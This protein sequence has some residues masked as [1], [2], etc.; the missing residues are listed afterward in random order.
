MKIVINVYLLTDLIKTAQALEEAERIV[1]I[2]ASLIAVTYVG[3]LIFA[4]CFYP[5]QEKQRKDDLLSDLQMYVHKSYYFVDAVPGLEW[6]SS[7]Y[8]T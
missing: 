6:C 2:L 5:W 4:V 7:L 1:I 8:M 3:L